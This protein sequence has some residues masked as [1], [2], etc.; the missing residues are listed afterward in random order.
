M[1]SGHHHKTL[2]HPD[3]IAEV[4]RLLKDKSVHKYIEDMNDIGAV[5]Y[6]HKIP[7][8]GGSSKDGRTYYLDRDVP[9]KLRQFVLWHERVEKALRTVKGMSYDRAH[10]LATAAERMNVE[11][12]GRDWT[13]YKREI[14]GIVR[15]N[16]KEAPHKMP[17][18]FDTG[19]YRESNSMGMIT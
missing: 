5:D 3:L 17:A 8:T 12:S 7:L 4:E 2:H 13:A 15:A 1:S 14:A 9:Q 18:G 11:E 6:K 19:P 10:N 16:E